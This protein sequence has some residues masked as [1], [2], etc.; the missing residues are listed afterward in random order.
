MWVPLSHIHIPCPSNTERHLASL[1]VVGVCF[2]LAIIRQSDISWSSTCTQVFLSKAFS[3]PGL[4]GSSKTV[5]SSKS[6]SCPSAYLYVCMRRNLHAT[7]TCHGCPFARTPS[8][9]PPKRPDQ[10]LTPVSSCHTRSTVPWITFRGF[11][12]L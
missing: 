2:C 4:P 6:S 9:R 3:V 10:L 8:H 12:P 7:R 11:H 5:K 1:L